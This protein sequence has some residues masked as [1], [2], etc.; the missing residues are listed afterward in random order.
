MA[1]NGF[2]SFVVPNSDSNSVV[3]IPTGPN[4]GSVSHRYGSRS[5]IGRV[6]YAPM[7]RNFFGDW[8]QPRVSKSGTYVLILQGRLQKLFLQRIAPFVIITAFGFF[9][10]KIISPKFLAVVDRFR[11]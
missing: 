1:V 2:I 11:G 5:G 9:A 10:L 3:T 4:H 7:R 8:I 6:I